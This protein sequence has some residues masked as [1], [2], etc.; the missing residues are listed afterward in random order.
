MGIVG[1][2][3]FADMDLVTS[4]GT[5]RLTSSRTLFGVGAVFELGISP[6]I[7]F[8]AE[9]TYLQKGGTQMATTT[10]PNIDFKFTFLEIP[11]FLKI[12]VGEKIRPYV[13]AGPT[14]GFLLSSNAEGEVGGVVAGG[15]LQVYKADLNN[16]LASTDF[17][18]SVGAGASLALG[19]K[20]F[21][22]DGRYNIGS[23][24]LWE[25]GKF[26]WTSGSVVIPVEAN[27][28]GELSTKGFQVMGGV[29]FPFAGK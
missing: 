21:F 12:S 1:G 13:K 19:K 25:G 17:G 6:N 9:P 27:E 18:F 4:T 24:D 23:K 14:I 29:I 3:N 20:I 26:E 15:P 22:L 8:E 5:E 28:E 10:D 2:P 7:S 11:L 16:V